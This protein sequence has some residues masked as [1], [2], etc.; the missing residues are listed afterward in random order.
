MNVPTQVKTKVAITSI[1]DG[2]SNT[3]MWSERTL[4]TDSNS[5]GGG[6]NSYDHTMIYLLPD[7]DDGWSPYTPMTGTQVSETNPA[8]W[9]QG[10]TYKC[11]AYDYGP[12]SI[13]RYRGLEY[14]RAIPEMCQYTHTVPPNYMGYDCGDYNITMAHIAARSYHTGG[15]N[16]CFADG[17]VHFISSTIPLAT[18]QALGTRSAGDIPDSSQY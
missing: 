9:I 8:A 15:V 10:T 13:I 4:S 2:T 11:N 14:Y 1:T 7:A 5:D 12:T 18:W 3:A 17:S 16:V 6:K